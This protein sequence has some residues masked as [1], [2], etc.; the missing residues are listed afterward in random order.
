MSEELK[1]ITEDMYTRTRTLIGEEALAKLSAARVA[2]FGLGGEIIRDLI[3]P[4][5]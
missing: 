2:V 3:S 4:G 5:V 1:V